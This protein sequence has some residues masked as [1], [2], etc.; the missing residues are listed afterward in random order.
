ME[1]RIRHASEK[2]AQWLKAEYQSKRNEFYTFQ[3]LKDKTQ[4]KA[5]R[6]ANLFNVLVQFYDQLFPK[7]FQEVYDA[8]MHVS[9]PAR[10]MIARQGSVYFTNSEEVTPLLGSAYILLPSLWMFGKFF[11][12]N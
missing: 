6:Y 5:S 10:T 9:A 1:S 4:A 11:F 2:E 8:D 12:N 3:E 7:Y